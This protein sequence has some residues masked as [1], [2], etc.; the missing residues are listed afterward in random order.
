MVDSLHFRESSFREKLVEHMFIAE[1]LKHSWNIARN[2]NAPL[3]EISRAEVDRCGY[4]LIAEYGG[5][6]RHIQLKGS[7]KNAKVARQKVHAA[8]EGKPSA[9]VVWVVLNDE[10]WSLGPFYFFGGVPG[11]PIPELGD[12]VAKHEKG[13]ASGEK[14]E[15]PMMRTVNK[16]NF[17]KL[18][19]VEHLWEALF[20]SS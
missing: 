15:R 3:I 17:R 8:L 6:I 5:V 9:C 10:D 13:D 19:S 2:S 20:G 18:L 7:V 4:D 12:K 1:L 16:G 14:K 11:D